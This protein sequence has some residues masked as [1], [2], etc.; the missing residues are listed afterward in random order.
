MEI[1]DKDSMTP[2]LVASKN[3]NLA[4]ISWLIDNGADVTATDKDDK[5]CLMLAV[6]VKKTQAVQVNTE[7]LCTVA[8]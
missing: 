3:G 5:S 7:N 4:T 1:R 2:L 8:Y 6:E